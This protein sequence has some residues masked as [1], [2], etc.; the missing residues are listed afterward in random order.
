MSLRVRRVSI[1]IAVV[2]AAS[3]VL[4]AQSDE[5]RRVTESATILS[6]IVGAQD[7]SIPRSVIEKAEAIVVFPSTLKAG[8][9]V[10]G[11]RG[12]GIVSARDHERGGW[13]PPAF[14]T[15]TG[16]SVGVQ[17]GGEAVDLVLCVMNRRGLDTLLRNQFKLGVDASVA[18]GPVG[19]EAEAATDLQMRAEILSYS[20]ARGVFAGLSIKGSSIHQDRD[21]NE[22][23][24]NYPFRTRDIVLDGKAQRPESAGSWI[25]ALKRLAG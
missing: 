20:R 11:H 1:S 3:V 14:L 10:G 9:I 4:L 7:N 6:E 17:I 25:D 19:R 2:L 23:F 18:A 8:F 12:R 24:Y 5:A 22:R 13:S 16:G 15:L 21:A